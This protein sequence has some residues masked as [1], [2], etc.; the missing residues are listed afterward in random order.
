MNNSP[1]MT[2]ALRKTIM[3]RSRLESIYIRKGN[4][5]SGKFKKQI[6]FCVD[7]RLKTK[8]EYFK[9]LNVKDISGER[10]FRKTIKS[11]FGNKG[12]N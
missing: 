1:L 6:K 3:H 9:D 2:K 12:L 4:E 8:T 7:L 5:N 11:C 10:T